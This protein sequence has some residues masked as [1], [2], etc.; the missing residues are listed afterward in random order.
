MRLTKSEVEHVALLARLSLKKE[1]VDKFAKQLSSILDYVSQL[2]EVKT[3]GVS[4]TAQVTGLENMMRDDVIEACGRET[5]GKMLGNAP[6]V[7]KNLIKTKS[8][9]E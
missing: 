8:V 2:Q 1:E 4:E 5:I 9:F 3:D 7:E 6:E